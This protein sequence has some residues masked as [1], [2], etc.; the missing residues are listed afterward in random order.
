MPV[1]GAGMVGVGMGDDCPVHRPAGVDVEIPGRAVQALGP[2]DQQIGRMGHARSQYRP[3]I[4]ARRK[5][6]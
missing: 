4:P 3:V 6:Q 2:G 5:N 1:S